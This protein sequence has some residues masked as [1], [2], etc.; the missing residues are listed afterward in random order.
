MIIVP[1]IVNNGL[2]SWFD[3]HYLAS[4]SGSGT[5]L[6]NIVKGAGTTINSS[7]T[8]STSNY[9]FSFNGSTQS[10]TGTHTVTGTSASACLWVYPVTTGGATY[11]T[12]FTTCIFDNVQSGISF[13]QRLNG[14]YWIF[15]GIWGV[16]GEL[17]EVPYTINQWM[18]LGITINGTTLFAYK[19]G[20]LVN[21]I[22]CS[23][24]LSGNYLALGK[25][26]S[27]ATEFFDG[28][29]ASL[30]LYNRALTAAEINQNFQVTR[31]RFGI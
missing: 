1:K 11:R 18:E 7:P 2:V 28:R 23:R 9:Y 22:P 8:F 17:I 20:V 4:Y 3:P 6:N 31:K 12:P 29:I 13:Q 21:S 30:K 25:G 24:S 14:N 5:A 26:A 15:C 19:N 10:I 16:A 27:G